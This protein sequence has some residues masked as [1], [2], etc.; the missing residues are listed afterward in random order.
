MMHQ[1]LTIYSIIK[2]LRDGERAPVALAPAVSAQGP[3]GTAGEES[4]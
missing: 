1:T 2:N 4:W 3:D